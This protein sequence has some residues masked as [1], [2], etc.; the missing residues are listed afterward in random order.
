ML[1]LFMSQCECYQ[2]KKRYTIF[3][4]KLLA[5]LFWQRTHEEYKIL[6]YKL[7]KNLQKSFQLMK[8]ILML[9]QKSVSICCHFSS[10]SVEGKKLPMKYLHRLNKRECLWFILFRQ[11]RGKY[12]SIITQSHRKSIYKLVKERITSRMYRYF[13]I[14]KTTI[15]HFR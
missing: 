14:K 15:K 10:T 2:K 5:R 8:I 3:S 9:E 4:L 6:N 12:I 11:N 7:R 1:L 13:Y